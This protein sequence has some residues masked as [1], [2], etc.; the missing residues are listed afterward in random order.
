MRSFAAQWRQ[1]ETTRREGERA[2]IDA[3]RP[4]IDSG[5]EN[6]DANRGVGGIWKATQ[7]SDLLGGRAGVR[8]I[9][10]RWRDR[11]DAAQSSVDVAN[12]RRR[13]AV[14]EVNQNAQGAKGAIASQLAL[15]MGMP[16]RDR[17]LGR[18]AATRQRRA[19]AKQQQE[20]QAE[21]ALS[22]QER[23]AIEAQRA[24][25]R[26]AALRGETTDFKVQADLAGRQ[27]RIDALSATAEAHRQGGRLDEARKVEEQIAAL[28]ISMAD[29]AHAHEMRQLRE[30]RDAALAAAGSE[31]ER[32]VL[33]QRFDAEQDFLHAGQ[34]A[35]VARLKDAMA[36]AAGQAQTINKTEGT[37]QAGIAGLM[38]SPGIQERIAKAGETTARNT[39]AM[40]RQSG[41]TITVTN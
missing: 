27:G 30:R 29:Q 21:E 41:A 23:M 14:D 7:W 15:T 39:A 8:A 12:E 9:V 18:D 19:V 35:A 31:E 26:L 6:V 11:I 24:R 33:K 13:M 4:V 36:A 3:A 2:A 10:P 25:D 34:V 1:V 22:Q 20:Q 37:F 17:L 28:R 5:N 32:T 38:G 40:A 16:I